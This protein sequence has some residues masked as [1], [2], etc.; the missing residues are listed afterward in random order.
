MLIKVVAQAVLVYT[1]SVFKLL[2]ELCKNIQKKLLLNSSENMCEAKCRSGLRFR[3]LT[4]F[5]QMLVAKQSWRI[6]KI[7]THCC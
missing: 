2:I 5:K 3:D 6:F 1:I 7:P 4:C